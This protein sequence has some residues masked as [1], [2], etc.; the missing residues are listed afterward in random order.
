MPRMRGD[1]LAR[2]LAVRWPQLPVVFM[3]GYDKGGVPRGG[4]LLE[5]PVS[6]ASLLG[7]IREVLD[8]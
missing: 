6:E 3:S 7:A 2:E 5:K 4:R 8:V 1:E